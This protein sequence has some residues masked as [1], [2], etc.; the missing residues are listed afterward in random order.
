[1]AVRLEVVVAAWVLVTKT[2]VVP[3]EMVEV[4]SV[5]EL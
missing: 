4:M 5:S 2:T 1:M 3:C